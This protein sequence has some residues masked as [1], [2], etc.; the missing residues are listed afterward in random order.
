MLSILSQ[1]Q[2]PSSERSVFKNVPIQYLEQVQSFYRST[3]AGGI[4]VSY[5]FRGPRSHR[6]T[7]FWS[8]RQAR[9]FCLKSDAVVFSVYVYA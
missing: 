2:S 9:S 5:R 8:G 7:D 4:R 3:K 1:Y 6:A